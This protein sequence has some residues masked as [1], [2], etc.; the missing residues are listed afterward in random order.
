MKRLFLSALALSFAF[1][2][3]AQITKGTTFIGGGLSFG[4]SKSTGGD[5]TNSYTNPHSSSFNISPSISWAV[6]DNLVFGVFLGYG[7]SKTD[8]A[9]TN[10][11][12]NKQDNY[13]A[14]VFLRK[15]K[16]VGSGFN[17]F[18]QG[19][20]NFAY[21]KTSNE[22]V[23]Q[24]EFTSTTWGPS[25]GLAPG[26][27]YRLSHHWQAE[28]MLP[29]LVSVYYNHTSSSQENPGMQAYRPVTNNFGVSTSVSNL[30]QFTLGILYSI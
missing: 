16:P 8:Y 6:K 12:V 15:Y 3:Q 9:A 10:T 28:A 20:L 24:Y 1:L 4:D 13:S 23:Q 18:L 22:G 29:G 14:G 19:N 7:H 17:L 30:T 27:A 25:L 21:S 2:T 11:P 26:I 5:T